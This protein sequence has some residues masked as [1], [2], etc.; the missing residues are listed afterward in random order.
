VHKAEKEG[1]I[2]QLG[3]VPEWQRRRLGE[4]LLAAT[5]Y[6]FVELGLHWA[7]LSVHLSNKPAVKP[8]KHAGFA[9][10]RRY[11]GFAKDLDPSV[12]HATGAAV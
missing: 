1:E 9:A 4:A 11:V 8:L 12:S 6:G 10:T 3:A 5:L 7:T 2:G